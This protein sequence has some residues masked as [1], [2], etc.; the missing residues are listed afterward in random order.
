MLMSSEDKGMAQTY[1]LFTK[2]REFAAKH[3]L[4]GFVLLNGVVQ[5][6]NLGLYILGCPLTA[7]PF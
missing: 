4:R 5:E 1:S 7:V 3:A 6:S 2:L